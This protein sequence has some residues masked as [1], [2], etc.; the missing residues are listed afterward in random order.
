MSDRYPTR[1]RVSE[2]TLLLIE[3]EIR[4]RGEMTHMAVRSVKCRRAARLSLSIMH[5]QGQV[6]ISGWDLTLSHIEIPIYAY[7]PGDDQPKSGQSYSRRLSK[8]RAAIS[9]LVGEDVSSAFCDAVSKKIPGRIVAQRQVIYQDG[10][11]NW[12]GIDSLISM[13]G[14]A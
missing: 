14:A 7:G 10:K 2:K 6:H 8:A 5:S 3:D 13:M 9:D 11:P 1:T 4:E 12:P